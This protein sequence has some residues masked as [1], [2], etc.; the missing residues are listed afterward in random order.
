MRK[1]FFEYLYLTR[2]ER[3]GLLT[4][5]LVSG[6]FFLI[7]TVAYFFR[8][9]GATDFTHFLTDIEHFQ[10][11][12]SIEPVPFFASNKYNKSFTKQ[13]AV[14][15]TEPFYFDPNKASKTDF[16]K[17]GISERT[18][19]TIV[20]FR[21]TGA[22][23]YKKEDLKKVYG[24][25]EADYARLENF[26]QIEQQHKP[27]KKYASSS[28]ADKKVPKAYD[29]PVINPTNFDPNTADEKM[30][31]QN[32]IPPYVV[33][34]LLNFR[35]SGAKF[36]QKE[37]LKKIYNLDEEIFTK[38][39]PYIEI[40]PM[41]KKVIVK[42]SAWKNEEKDI[43]EEEFKNI[44]ID[45]NNSTAED[46]QKLRGI[47]PSFSK[48]II[49]YRD[50]LGGFHTIAQVG[51]AYGLPDSTFQIIKPY[52]E[53]SAILNKINLNQVTE[54]ELKNHPYVS[55]N[56]AKVIISYRNMHDGFKSVEELLKIGAV[57]K[58]WFETVKMYFEVPEE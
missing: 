16:V 26:I 33:K 36:Y 54:E 34:T 23:F 27:K 15:P 51:E 8:E 43:V 39:E 55:W 53:T 58:D 5:L 25:K 22:K 14:P 45:I 7:P 1:H 13:E 28:F 48:R 41:E 32:G 30:L 12:K 47:G 6:L 18:A 9:K 19:N 42:A 49:K 10:Q 57:K 56:Q 21:K 29:A 44:I 17:L 35:N 52:L 38:I 2:Q 3:N 24:F 31:L 11:A 40:A 4:T 46:W 50:R 37:D 20:N